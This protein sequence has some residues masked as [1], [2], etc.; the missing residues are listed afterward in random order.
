M[1]SIRT[2]IYKN[3]GQFETVAEMNRDIL[4]VLESITSKENF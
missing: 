2:G 3:H 1:G 4:E